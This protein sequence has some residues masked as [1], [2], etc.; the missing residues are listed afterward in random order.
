MSSSTASTPIRAAVIGYGMSAKIFHI[1]FLLALPDHFTLHGILQRTPTA[2]S[3][4]ARDHPSATIYPNATALLADPAVTLVIITST[5]DS[6]VDLCT[7]AL[8]AGKH[9]LCEKPFTPTS[10]EALS[11][12][13]HAK[14]ANRIL[15]VYQNRR[16]DADFLTLRALVAD[17]ALG[18]VAEA[19]SH[20]DR[21][22]PD[23][24]APDTATW[25]AKPGPAGGAIFDLGTHLLDQLVVLF[26]KPRRVTAFIGN[27]RTYTAEGT[28]A[29]AGG[30]SFTVM[31]HYADGLL[32]TAKAGVVS[33]EAAQLRF[34]VR[35]TKGSYKK[36]HL[37]VQEDQLKAGKRPGADKRFGVEPMEQRGS[38]TI[39]NP[40]TGV[41]EVRSVGDEDAPATYSA[42]YKALAAALR[43][44]GENPVPAEQAAVVIR[45]I[46]LA[47]MS[48]GE[49]RTVDVDV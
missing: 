4:A 6:H 37:D 20:F 15:A 22:R 49:G 13:A 11:L 44:Q 31:L 16:W 34:W 41:P 5:P 43:G 35:G 39:I 40:A 17:N 18:R 27:Q 12:A 1:P 48:S 38:V 36:H 33:P 42:F 2:K 14:R 30:D 26:G 21:H 45:L 46:E 7:Q 47:K 25:K 23:P 29:D 24:P 3:N 10:A 19:E 9:V 8:D 28:G 32:C